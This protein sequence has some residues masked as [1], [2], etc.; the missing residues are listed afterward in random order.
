MVKIGSARLML[1]GKVPMRL[2]FNAMECFCDFHSITVPGMFRNKGRTG[3]EIVFGFTPDISEYV[4]FRFYDYCFYW[5]TPQGYPH[6][7]DTLVDG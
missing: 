2:W 4:E 5:D 1:R 7:R 3:F 6:E